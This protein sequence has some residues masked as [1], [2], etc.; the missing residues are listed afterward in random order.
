MHVVLRQTFLRSPVVALLAIAGCLTIAS[1]ASAAERYPTHPVKLIVPFPPG[2]TTDILARMMA[3]GLSQQLGQPF[4][5]ENRAGASGM[6]G[7]EFVARANDGGYTIGVATVT[8]HAINPFVHK[9]GFDVKK[10]LVP[11]SNMA[12]V[13]NV[14]VV[15]PALGVKTLAEL[16]A[17]LKQ[18]PGKYTYATSGTG[19]EGHVGMVGYTKVS[20]TDALHVPYKG[21]GPAIT[22]TIA[23]HTQMMQ[24]NLPSLLPQIE[25]GKLVAL[26]VTSAQRLAVLP[27]VPTYSEAGYPEL[28]RSAWFGL[29]APASTPPEV[30]AR[31]N[32][33]ATTVLSSPATRQAIEKL[34]GQAAPGSA[35]EFGKT[36][37]DELTAQKAVVTWANIKPE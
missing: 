6:I 8:T 14:L 18:H 19:A 33:A 15:N 35:A 32:A 10:D 4:V 20:G 23:G 1:P 26:A 5:V 7:S 28:A 21:G 37:D 9:L 29:V 17:L 12:F 22:D 3:E 16:T 13:P 27:D 11:V 34:G 36:M 2:G 25:A 24:G 30:V 31:L